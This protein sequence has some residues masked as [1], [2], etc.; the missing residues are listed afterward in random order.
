MEFDLARTNFKE[1]I[2]FEGTQ[3]RQAYNLFIDK[4]IT[5]FEG[6]IQETIKNK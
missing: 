3:Q 2:D 5:Y 4:H 1:I 6:N